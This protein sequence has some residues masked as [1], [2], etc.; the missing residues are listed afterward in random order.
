MKNKIKYIASLILAAALVWLAFRTVEWDSFFNGLKE[1]RWSYVFLFFIAS[2]LA[3]VFRQE[4]WKMIIS[5]HNPNIRRI[6]TWDS[7]NVGNIVNIVLPGAGEFVRCGYISSSRLKYDKALGTIVCERAFDVLAILLLLALSFILNWGR[8][9][10]FFIESV[11]HPLSEKLNFSLWW[12]VIAALLI[13]AGAVWAIYHFRDRNRFCGKI[14]SAIKGIFAGISGITQIS[15]KGLFLLHTCCI[16]L[17]YVLM[18]YFMFKAVPSL[19]HLGLADAM[20]VS[21]IGNIASIIPVPGGI[22]AYHYLAALCLQSVYGISWDTGILFA[23]LNHE[24][25]AILVVVLGAIS[26]SAITL[27]RKKLKD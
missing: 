9:G 1:T 27:R 25:H 24:L 15:H 18:S 6:E 2:I 7:T 5:P 20:F 16:W 22:G 14:V 17:M 12:V 10:S 11:W 4:R 23:T 19:A 26:Y 8:F 21:A 13:C 3:L